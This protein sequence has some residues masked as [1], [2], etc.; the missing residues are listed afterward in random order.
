MSTR[1]NWN[2]QRVLVRWIA[3]GCVAASS[4]T[5]WSAGPQLYASGPG[6]DASYVRFV[7]ATGK[8]L[9]I[10]AAGKPA[11]GGRLQL[12]TANAVGSFM[13]IKP[14][15]V[16]AGRAVQGKQSLDLAPA[17]QAGE[18]VSVVIWLRGDGTLVSTAIA[19]LP[20]TFNGLKASLAFYN[21]DPACPAAGL[22]AAGQD[23]TLFTG[24]APNT[25]QRR[26]INP[27]PLSVKVTCDALVVGKPLDLGT[28][29]SGQRYS[30]FLVA[31]GREKRAFWARDE[32]AQ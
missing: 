27:V 20:K 25:L 2:T 32:M 8:P 7:N 4:C 13:P 12:G 22:S 15:L 29:E 3:A 30:V 16:L 6:E 23:T 5:A 10:I 19:E 31:D 14:K 18:L 1:M 11:T 24:G 21:V 28:L 9:D 26:P 17:A